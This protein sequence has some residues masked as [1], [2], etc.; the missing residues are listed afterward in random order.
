MI[1]HVK[2]VGYYAG[3]AFGVGY[4]LVFA[5]VIAMAVEWLA[6]IPA[7][8]WSMILP[9]VP[10]WLIT[11]LICYLIAVILGIAFGASVISNSRFV[12]EKGL[13]LS[14]ISSSVSVFCFMI[15][16]A[17][18]G[19][20][21]L[22][23][24]VA[25]SSYYGFL[26]SSLVYPICNIVGAILLFIGFRT[27]QG[28]QIESKIM[29]AVMMLISVVLIY[30]VALG[31]V[32]SGFSGIFGYAS[33]S[34]L[35][36]VPGPLLAQSALETVALLLATIAAI[37]LA[38]LTAEER[39]KNAIGGVILS[40]SAILF[41]IGLMYV[42]FSA[43]STFGN[44]LSSATLTFRSLWVLFFGFLV[45]GISGIIVIV[46]AC[47]VLALAAMQLSTRQTQPATQSQPPSP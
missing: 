38:F 26:G 19:S 35:P 29:G 37:V 40:A 28:K 13:H 15:I 20:I 16:F 1:A 12:R 24:G 21:I 27:Y 39:I 25:S 10:A 44:M 32:A 42:N 45:L 9:Y 34:W 5:G 8:V 33:S 47:L 22:I 36:A 41:S 23:S 30:I 31:P 4:I 43:V 14:M 18:I 2:M 7:S 17:A 3:V 6:N 11:G 46:T